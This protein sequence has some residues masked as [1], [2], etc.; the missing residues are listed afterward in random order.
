MKKII[1]LLMLIFGF[2]IPMQIYAMDTEENRDVEMGVVKNDRT[3]AL[4]DDEE[5]IDLTQDVDIEC[6]S[7]WGTNP[8]KEG[9]FKDYAR[10]TICCRKECCFWNPRAFAPSQG[11]CVCMV[12]TVAVSAFLLFEYS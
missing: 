9:E 8:H 4:D 12:L 10:R 3:V 5:V 2:V 11:C 1:F 6:C 7:L